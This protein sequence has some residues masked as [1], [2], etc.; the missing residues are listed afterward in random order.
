MLVTAGATADGGGDLTVVSLFEVLL[1]VE[2]EVDSVTMACANAELA[3][4]ARI[5]L[6]IIFFILQSSSLG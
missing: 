6:I 5:P 2:L 1:E 4:K 3:T